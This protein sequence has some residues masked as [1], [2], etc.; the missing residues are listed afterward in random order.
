MI[1][2][3]KGGLPPAAMQ[4]S[5]PSHA[6]AMRK[7]TAS[8]SRPGDEVV[9]DPGGIDPNTGR[10]TYADRNPNHYAANR[11]RRDQQSTYQGATPQQA[12]HRA[13]YAE[14]H[15]NHAVG[16]QQGGPRQPPMPQPMQQPPQMQFQPYPM[17][18][19]GQQL[20]P[21]QGGLQGGFGPMQ[22]R[23]TYDPGFGAQFSPFQNPKFAGPG[24]SAMQQIGGGMFG[25]GVPYPMQGMPARNTGPAP[26][27]T[28]RGLMNAPSGGGERL[29][30]GIYRGANGQAVRR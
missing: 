18:M 15:P 28:G 2:G 19:Q 16:M 9:T 8:I 17:P 11:E 6:G 25:G 14:R 12:N 3:N 26:M 27:P 13:L 21:M 10:V 1:R 23:P 4:T 5:K 30:P 20:P 7:A 22:G 29:S 24:S